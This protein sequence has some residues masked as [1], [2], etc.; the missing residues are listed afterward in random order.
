MFSE[1]DDEAKN[2]DPEVR[3]ATPPP[4]VPGAKIDCV[5]VCGGLADIGAV[6]PAN[7]CW[8]REPC[9]PER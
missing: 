6:C 7:R 5:R 8:S 2:S 1:L 3:H 9:Y 4:P